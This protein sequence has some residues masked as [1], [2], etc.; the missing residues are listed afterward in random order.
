MV[1][2][3]LDEGLGERHFFPAHTGDAGLDLCAAELVTK[4]GAVITVE[5]NERC[6]LSTGVSFSVPYGYHAE[7]VNRYWTGSQGLILGSSMLDPTY[8]EPLVLNYW[9]VSKNKLTLTAREARMAQIV[10][11]GQ[12]TPDVQILSAEDFAKVCQ[13]RFEQYVAGL[14]KSGYVGS[15]IKRP[16]GIKVVDPEPA[17]PQEFSGHRNIRMYSCVRDMCD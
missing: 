17:L 3:R 6:V 14:K 1:Y 16:V 4:E 12:K 15:V 7:I 10:F 9:N 5:P 2:V 11:Y 8:N 13:V